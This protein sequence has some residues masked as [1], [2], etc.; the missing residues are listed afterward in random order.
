MKKR[1][2]GKELKDGRKRLEKAAREGRRGGYGAVV[3][4]ELI[5]II[6]PLSHFS[7][8]FQATRCRY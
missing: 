3:L 7:K 5:F 6:M 2:V 8:N 4:S 1:K